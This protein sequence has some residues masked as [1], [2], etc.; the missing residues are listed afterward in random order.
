VLGHLLRVTEL[1]AHAGDVILIHPLVLH[2][3]PVNAG[4]APRLL[5]NKDLHVQ[6]ARRSADAR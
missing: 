5:L 1:T 4:T 2:A 6:D 3:R